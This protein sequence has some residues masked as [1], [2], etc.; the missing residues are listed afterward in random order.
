M[1]MQDCSMRFFGV[2]LAFAL[3]ITF[4]M[5]LFAE[6]PDV[7]TSKAAPEFTM[8]NFKTGKPISLSDYKG[9]VVIIDFWATWCVPCRK[10]IKF[11]E[12]LYREKYKE[13][14]M[15]IAVSIDQRD[16][17]L[18]NYLDKRPLSY[19][20]IHDPD[21]ELMKKYGVFKVP[22]TFIID[23]DGKIQNKYVGIMEEVVQKKVEELLK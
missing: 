11:Y 9:K 2:V 5:P 10:A 19:P 6:E 18:E 17:K 21:K 8:K 4:T 12:K 13:G 3:A 20:V 22:T 7:T 14:L 16:S 1:K 15:V 23:K